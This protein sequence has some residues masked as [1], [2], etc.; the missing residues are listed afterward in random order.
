[1]AA[2]AFSS[3]DFFTMTY[4]SINVESNLWNNLLWNKF[5]N[6]RFQRAVVTD[7]IVH[8]NHTLHSFTFFAWKRF[9]NELSEGRDSLFGRY[10][11]FNFLTF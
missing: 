2:P 11:V 9:R 5:E 4:K 1:V 3:L 6:V 8:S 7:K 10:S